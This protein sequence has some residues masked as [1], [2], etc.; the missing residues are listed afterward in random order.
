M[1]L[2][3]DSS[4]FSS[5]PEILSHGSEF[6]NDKLHHISD[7]TYPSTSQ[8]AHSQYCQEFV[9]DENQV[10]RP[11]NPTE[12]NTLTD[13]F[14]DLNN[15]ITLNPKISDLADNSHSGEPENYQTPGNNSYDCQLKND[16]STLQAFSQSIS[17]THATPDKPCCHIPPTSLSRHRYSLNSNSLDPVDPTFSSNLSL[18]CDNVSSDSPKH[19][20]NEMNEEL[21][22][23]SYDNDSISVE[24]LDEHKYDQTPEDCLISHGTEHKSERLEL[25]PSSSNISFKP[26]PPMNIALRRKKVRHRPAALTT[27][28]LRSRLATGPCTISH[29]EGFYLPLKSPIGSPTRKIVSAGGNQSVVSGRIHK[30]KFET[31]PRSPIYIGGFETVDGFM[32]HNFLNFYNPP[33][34]TDLSSLCGSL[35]SSTP[36]EINSAGLDGSKSSFSNLDVSS[37]HLFNFNAS[38]C[39]LPEFKGNHEINSHPNQP[40]PMF[41]NSSESWSEGVDCKNNQFIFETPDNQD[42]SSYQDSFAYQTNLVDTVSLGSLSKHLNSALAQ[43]SKQNYLVDD[44]SPPHENPY[45]AHLIDNEYSCSDAKLNSE[46]LVQNY[47]QQQ[48]VFEFS[49]TTPADFGK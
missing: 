16:S 27:D 23:V 29:V 33:S 48:K 41:Q 24:N 44:L 26:R 1:A 2:A 28:S 39:F 25:P 47:K 9:E 18:N 13:G 11:Q 37:N 49:H 31:N 6:F 34:L 19:G 15:N 32:E 21:N 36:S 20:L 35:A 40:Q 12:L 42:Y 43:Q 5:S 46:N 22:F 45:F 10:F 4:T 3:Q 8:T 7:Q 30:S 38:S 17:Q 14:M